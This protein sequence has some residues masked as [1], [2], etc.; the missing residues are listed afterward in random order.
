MY[1]FMYDHPP[2]PHPWKSDFSVNPH[3]IQIFDPYPSHPLKVT[4][5]LIKISQFKF[6]AVTK[7][8]IFVNNNLI[9]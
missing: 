3:D 6:F 9:K 5:F 2:P 7:K 4:K 1:V 8:I